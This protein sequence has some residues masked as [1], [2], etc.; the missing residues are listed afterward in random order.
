MWIPGQARNDKG[1]GGLPRYA[2]AKGRTS[3]NDGE[4]NNEFVLYRFRVKP[5]MT[6]RA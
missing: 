6:G 1:G 3:C 4:D 5:G 2:S